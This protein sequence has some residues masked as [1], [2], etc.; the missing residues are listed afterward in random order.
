[1]N[2]DA[3]AR[4]ERFPCSPPIAVKPPNVNPR[5]LKRLHNRKAARRESPIEY[6]RGPGET[7][8]FHKQLHASGGEHVI[9]LCLKSCLTQ[10]PRLFDIKV[11]ESLLACKPPPVARLPGRRN[12]RYEDNERLHRILRALGLHIVDLRGAGDVEAVAQTLAAMQ[13]GA[14]VIAQAGL[15]CGSWFGRADVL[16]KVGT[17][18]GLA[19]WSYEVYDCK[20]A[21]E[22]RAGTILQ[23]A[24]ERPRRRGCPR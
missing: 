3:T 15:Q 6:N 13:V 24:C 23:S 20:L 21:R 14:E 8:G 1:M 10:Y 2:R 9:P 19:A 18:S 11:H 22:T 17:P 4:Q 7:Q 16:R 12:A 5:I